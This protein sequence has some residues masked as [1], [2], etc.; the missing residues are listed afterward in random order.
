MKTYKTALLALLT[1][2]LLATSVYADSN[3]RKGPRDRQFGGPGF[4]LPHAAM[5]SDRMAERLG[6]DETQR[7]RVDNIMSAASPEMEAL[8]EKVKLNHE[9]LRALGAGDPEVQNI[10]LSNGELATEATLLFARVR[11][12]LDAV[13]TD[14]QRATLAEL[15][16]RRKDRRSERKNRR[17]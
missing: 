6:L 7:E 14:E 1:S 11:G 12:E 15:K 13:L 8:R 5:I 9:A 16:D 4:G 2:G 10:A 3:D 17:Q